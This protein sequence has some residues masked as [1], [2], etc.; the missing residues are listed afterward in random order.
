M[1]NPIYFV[2]DNHF[3]KRTDDFEMDRRKKFFKLIDHIKKTGGS[4]VIAGD[5]FDFWFEYR[6]FVPFEYLDLFEKLKDL[7]ESG[8]SIHYILGNHDFW[9]FGFFKKTFALDILVDQY[10]ISVNNHKIRVIHG[11]GVLK[12]DYMYRL[13]RSLIRSRACIFLFK[14]LSPKM[15]YYIASLIS[16]ADQ[17]GNYYREN[18]ELKVKLKSYAKTK[19][20]ECD[21]LLVGHYHQTGIVKDRDKRLIF[22]GDW[23]SKFTVTVYNNGEWEQLQWD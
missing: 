21:T 19:W 20:G 4:L 15:G 8:H 17:H 16:Q 14:L 5:F 10:N 22:L 6:G 9:D 3:Q 23:L 2:S 11:D 13:F 12:G 1:D 7:K 18:D